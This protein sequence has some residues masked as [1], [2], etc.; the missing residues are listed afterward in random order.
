MHLLRL[1]AG[2][3]ASPRRPDKRAQ[4][5]DGRVPLAGAGGLLGVGAR[6]VAMPIDQFHWDAAKGG[7]K[8][9]KTEDDLKKMP[10]WKAALDSSGSTGYTTAPG[11]GARPSKP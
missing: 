11:S 6:D 9:A 4:G 10:E 7:F 5:F 1:A 8:I 3:G 2:H